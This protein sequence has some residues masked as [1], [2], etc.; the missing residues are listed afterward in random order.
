MPLSVLVRCALAAACAV[1][2]LLAGAPARAQGQP[3]AAPSS[4]EPWTIITPPQ[5]SLVLARDNSVIGVFG[6][7]RRLNVSVRALPRYVGQAFVAVEDKRFYQHNG[8][9]LVGIAGALKD[10]VTGDIRGA[11]TITE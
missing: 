6:R 5:A 9:D 1:P 4:G 2:V 11:S 8:V 10:A 3:A 7:E